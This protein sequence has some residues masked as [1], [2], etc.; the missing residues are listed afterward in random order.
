[1]NNQFLNSAESQTSSN[2]DLVSACGLYCGACGLY[3]ATQENDTEKLLQYAIVLNQSLGETFC[4]GC[5][6]G[7]NSAHCTK[8]CPLIKCKSEKEIEFCG[9]CPELPCTELKD[10]QPGMPLRV[11]ILKSQSRLMEISWEQ[12]LIEMKRITLARNASW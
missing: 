1:M 9:A 7:R 2:K 12:W 6:A 5:G 11:E 8:I 3:L 10:F 4:D